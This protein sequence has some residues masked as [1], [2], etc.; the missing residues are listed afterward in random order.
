M[1][2][3]ILHTDSNNS[4]T[5]FAEKIIDFYSN[6]E[7]KGNLPDGISVM[8]PFSNNGYQIILQ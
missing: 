3:L 7:F 5:L 1:K 2:C 4:M 6:L 8:N